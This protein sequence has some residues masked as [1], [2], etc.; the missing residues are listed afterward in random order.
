MK[1]L[2][3]EDEESIAVPLTEGLRREGFTVERAATLASWRAHWVTGASTTI[4]RGT[5]PAD[6]AIP[7][8]TYW[9]LW[10]L[11]IHDTSR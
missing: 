5:S 6:Q 7:P 11:P 4:T 1:I 2:L 3:V 8:A 9:S 10:R